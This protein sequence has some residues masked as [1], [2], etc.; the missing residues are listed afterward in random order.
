MKARV[1]REAQAPKPRQKRLIE[2]NHQGNNT[3]PDFPETAAQNRSRRDDEEQARRHINANIVGTIIEKETTAH[4]LERDVGNAIKKIIFT[5][6]A[7]RSTGTPRVDSQKQGTEQNHQ[8]G[9]I[10]RTTEEDSLISSDDDYFVQAVTN[11]FQP[12]KIK[13]TQKRKQTVIVRLND[14]DIRMEPDSGAEVSFPF[15]R[16]REYRLLRRLRLT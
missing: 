4:P 7:C 8:R 9:R 3:N 13:G 10:K 16:A 12:K 11:S 6:Y 14:V 5:Q 15:S 2:H 1:N